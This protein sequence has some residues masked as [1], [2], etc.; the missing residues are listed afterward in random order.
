MLDDMIL[1]SIVPVF[2]AMAL[3][4]LAGCLRRAAHE[5][6]VYNRRYTG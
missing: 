6:T 2:F 3:G 1:G 5:V 4:C